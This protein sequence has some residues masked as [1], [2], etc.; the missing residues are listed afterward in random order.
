MKY[1]TTRRSVITAFAA[2]A[3][4]ALAA[5]QVSTGLLAVVVALSAAVAAAA[6]A[7]DLE[8]GGL[9]APPMLYA[10]A[11]LLLPQPGLVLHF[12]PLVPRQVAL[13]DLVSRPEFLSVANDAARY[14]CACHVQS[15]CSS[16]RSRRR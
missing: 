16:G 6:L 13:R 2:T 14:P 1:M 3:I 10:A 12:G 7:R 5:S 8:A 15:S 11:A 9:N 4:V